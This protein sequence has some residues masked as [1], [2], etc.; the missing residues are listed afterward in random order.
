MKLLLTKLLLLQSVFAFSQT[1]E[2]AKILNRELQ[3]EIRYQKEDAENYYGD[4]FEVVKNFSIRDS[5]ITM[6]SQNI[7]PVTFE[8][9]RETL[10]QTETKILSIETKRKNSYDNSFY[11]EK[12]EVALDNITVIAKDINI[13]FETKPNAVKITR[14]EENGE[15]KVSENDLHFLQL[16]YEKNNEY[17]ADD[18]VKAFIKTGYNIEKGAWY[19]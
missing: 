2:I 11:T 13:I 8:V 6:I 14:T 19:D 15:K 10:I 12:K 9:K 17:L 1:K 5:M 18:L 7:D 16:S 3:K 4:K